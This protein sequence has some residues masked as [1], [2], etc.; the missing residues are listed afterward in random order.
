MRSG[1]MSALF[2][3]RFATNAAGLAAIP[4]FRAMQRVVFV[5]MNEI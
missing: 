1:A 5:N 2:A 4:Q 3:I